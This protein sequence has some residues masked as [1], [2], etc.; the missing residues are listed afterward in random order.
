MRRKVRRHL[1]GALAL[2]VALGLAALID[3]GASSGAVWIVAKDGSGR[4]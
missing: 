1:R 4:I 2:G 3:T